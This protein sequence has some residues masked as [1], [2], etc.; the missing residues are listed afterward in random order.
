MLILILLSLISVNLDI[1]RA[2]MEAKQDAIMDA[3]HSEC[4]GALLPGI[5]I[6][7][8]YEITPAVEPFRLLDK[9]NVYLLQYMKTYREEK[10]RID[11]GNA[12]FTSAWGAGAIWILYKLITL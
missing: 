7:A 6:I 5:S 9:S 1:E 11:L 2:Q 12:I 4:F 8:A 3:K 10:R